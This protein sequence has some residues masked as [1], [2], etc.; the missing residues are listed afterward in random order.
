MQITKE[1]SYDQT[2]YRRKPNSFIISKLWGL[3]GRTCIMNM[4]GAAS[5]SVDFF[6]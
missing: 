6:S 1:M 4:M 5:G 2:Y 3:R